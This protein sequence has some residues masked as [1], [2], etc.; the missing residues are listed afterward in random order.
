MDMKKMKLD[1]NRDTAHLVVSRGL[2]RYSGGLGHGSGIE[3]GHGMEL[4]RAYTGHSCPRGSEHCCE[5]WL[6]VQKSF[7]KHGVRGTPATDIPNAALKLNGSFV[8][9]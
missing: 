4:N 9:P 6:V 8:A 1:R 5:Y 3:R 2:S 7:G